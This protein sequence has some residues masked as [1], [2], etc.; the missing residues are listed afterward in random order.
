MPVCHQLCKVFIFPLTELFFRQLK[1][2]LMMRSYRLM[3]RQTHIYTACGPCDS[4]A[5]LSLSVW[6]ES[7]NGADTGMP[8]RRDTWTRLCF[9]LLYK[10]LIIKRVFNCARESSV[11][12]NNETTFLKLPHCKNFFLWSLITR[13]LAENKLWNKW[14]CFQCFLHAKHWWW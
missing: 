13:V 1:V 3:L 7:V 9:L 10:L 5:S 14:R 2:V 11:R 4:T 12:G 6:V 8:E